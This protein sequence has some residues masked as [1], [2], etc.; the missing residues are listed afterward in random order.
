MNEWLQ[1]GLA[2]V[3]VA[4]AVAVAV[5]RFL[6][7]VK[8]NRHASAACAGCPLKEQCRP[9]GECSCHGGHNDCC[10]ATRDKMRDKAQK[11]SSKKC[12]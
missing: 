12:H 8:G 4:I 1:T 7:I 6:R 2:L 3:I 5:K 9:A 10:E 11:K